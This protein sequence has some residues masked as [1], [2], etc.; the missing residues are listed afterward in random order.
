MNLLADESV[1]RQVVEALR[2]DGHTVTSIAELRPSIPDSEVLNE[3]KKQSAVLLT[4]YKDF[5]EL[6]FPLRRIHAGVVLLQLSGITPSAKG[7]LA[8]EVIRDRAAELPG[9][10]TVVTPSSVRIR[11]V[12]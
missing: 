2:Q 1:D 11:T 10:F 8:V 9:A 12:S 6:V 3:A 5:G 4:A 7:A